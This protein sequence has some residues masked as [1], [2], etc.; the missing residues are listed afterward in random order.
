MVEA[1]Q[2]LAPG[3]QQLLGDDKEPVTPALASVRQWAAA[4]RLTV[5]MLQQWP[6]FI[7]GGDRGAGQH[8]LAAAEYVDRPLHMMHTPAPALSAEGHWALKKRELI[9]ISHWVAVQSLP[10]F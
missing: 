5:A 8:P 4:G 9:T 6:L 1:P 3:Q 10:V 2:P 7:G